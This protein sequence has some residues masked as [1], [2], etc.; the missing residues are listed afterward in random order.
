MYSVSACDV[1]VDD[2]AGVA[3]CDMTLLV[4]SKS[5]ASDSE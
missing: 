4:D 1:T 3:L 2:D 5:S